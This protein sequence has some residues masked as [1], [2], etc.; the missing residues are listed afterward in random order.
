MSISC[1]GYRTLARAAFTI[2][3]PRGVG[4]AGRLVPNRGGK[5]SDDLRPMRHYG[6][7]E[8]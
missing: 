8:S 6:A 3:S 1:V 7:A 2:F 4:G 5:L